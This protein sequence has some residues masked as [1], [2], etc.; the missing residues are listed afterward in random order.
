[1]KECEISQVLNGISKRLD[2]LELGISCLPPR[3][4]TIQ[5]AARYTDLSKESIRRLVAKGKL[6][7]HRPVRGRVL[8]DRH[9]LE[10]FIRSS[11]SVPRNSR[12]TLRVK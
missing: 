8:I 3:F 7:A 4:L 11:V 9:E 1:M 5:N 10:A 12:G 2:S 6:T